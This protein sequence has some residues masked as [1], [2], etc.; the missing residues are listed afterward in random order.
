MLNLNGITVRLGGRTILDRAS[1][2]LP[3]RS[4]VGL[5]G[6]NGAGKSTL[7]KVMIGQIDPDEGSCD[8]PRDTRL[9]YIAQEAPSGTATPFDTVLAADRE[10]AELMAEA[11]H[12]Q[13][14]DRLGHIYERLNAIDAYTAPARAAR[15]LVGLGFDEE[16]QGRPLD[17]YSGGWKMRVALAALL[18]SNPD[19]LLLDEPSNHLDLE[20]TLW[21]ENFLKAYRGTVVV[22]SHERD[23]LNNVV[24]YILHLEGGKITLYPGGYDAFERQRAERLA[25]QEAARAKQQAE[26]EKLQDYVARN[27]ARASTAK[28]AQSRAKAL[29]RMQPIAAA[30]EDPTL[31]FGFPSPP[32]LRPP[33]ITMDMAA[34]GYNDTPVLRRVN[35]RIDPDDRLALLGRNGNGKTTLARLIAA[36][37]KPMEGAMN[38]SA[39]MNV[40]YFTQYQV[41][42]LDVG[43]TP[44]EHMSRVMKGATPAAVRA[45]LG[46]FGFSGERATQKVGSMSG[47]ERARLALALITRDA[48]HLLILDEPTNHLDVDSREALV[49]ALNDYSGAV[50]IVSHDR[51]MIEL[52]ADR[53]VLVDNG[54]A[55]PFDGSLEDYTDII[56]RKADGNGGNG[57]SGGDAPK[58]DRKAEKRNAA[59][60]R[61]RQK[62]A[63][64]AV[65]KAEK[66][67]AMLTAERSRIDQAL[68]DPKS[69]TGAEAKMT[70]TELMVKRADLERKLEAAEES[71]ME[72]SAALEEL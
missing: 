28:Q 6:R 12:T 59:Q 14:P 66:E 33:L 20:A 8:M 52:V 36:Q 23:L 34:V 57:G 16:M 68:F 9:G 32:E 31:H 1:A 50:V 21:L 64:N 69:A 13:D 65:S 42:E 7:M 48:P 18:F 56:L 25:Q 54:T 15:I 29:A 3:P 44:L 58:T 62:A 67:M 47:G 30:I 5:I 39:R 71:W 35:L 17:S 55:Q 37:L 41:E 53:L 2:S 26:R 22:I 45:Q 72:A 4:R 38:A 11:E 49:Q 27:S 51:H 61:E 43:D 63:K 70:M 46:R 24:D 19:L 10:R 40:G 60:W